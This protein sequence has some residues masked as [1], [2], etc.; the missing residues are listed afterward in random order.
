MIL[1]L[2]PFHARVAMC[3]KPV[4]L[5]FFLGKG[6]SWLYGE[7]SSRREGWEWGLDLG[8]I[9]GQEVRVEQLISERKTGVI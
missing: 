9:G 7:L 3:L 1:L 6:L 5:K 2:L 4:G 8:V